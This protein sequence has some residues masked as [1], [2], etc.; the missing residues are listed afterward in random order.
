MLNDASRIISVIQ[1]I[2]DSKIKSGAGIEVT[3]GQVFA[4]SSA[5]QECSVYL[6]GSREIAETYGELAIPTEGFRYPTLLTPYAGDYVKVSIDNRGHKWIEDII[7]VNYPKVSISPATGGLLLGDGSAPPEP[8]DWGGGGGGAVAVEENDTPVVAEASSLD[9]GNGLDVVDQG[10]GEVQISVDPSEIKLDDLG[11]PDDNTDLDATTGRHGLLPKVGS[12]GQ[13]PISR[14]S[15]PTWDWN[16]ASI[17]T[18]I[19]DGN[20][21]IGGGIKG[22]ISI[23]FDCQI[24]QARMLADQ[25]GSIVVDIWSDTYG[26][27]PPTAADSICGSAKPTIS[28]GTKSNDTTLTGW[29]TTLAEGSTLRYNVDSCSGITRVTVALRV[30]KL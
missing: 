18:E 12:T 29:T 5:Y 13:I 30:R 27:Y 26:N 22:D 2:V 8:A 9:F 21:V 23:P 4:T 20:F 24:V 25:T 10:G 11:T 3:Y 6:A 16:Y 28:S 7:P 15:V 1:K 19:Q 14:S 17:M